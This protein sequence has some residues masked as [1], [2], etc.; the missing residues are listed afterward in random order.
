MGWENL[1]ASL[2]SRK[3]WIVAGLIELDYISAVGN[4]GELH[5]RCEDSGGDGVS[6]EVFSFIHGPPMETCS[7][8]SHSVCG[9]STICTIDINRGG[10]GGVGLCVCGNW[11]ESLGEGGS[12]FPQAWLPVIYSCQ[13]NY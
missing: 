12:L 8:Y 11:T 7:S 1:L 13:N 3:S 6:F 2:L 10:S 5:R 9:T 4:I